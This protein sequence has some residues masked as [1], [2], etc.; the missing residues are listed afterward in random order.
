MISQRQPAPTFEVLASP[1]RAK[2]NIGFAQETYGKL[3]KE[4]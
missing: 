3:E 1:S 2:P 4:N